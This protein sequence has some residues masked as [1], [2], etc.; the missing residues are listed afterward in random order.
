MLQVLIS[1]AIK[2]TH[3]GH[4]IVGVETSNDGNPYDSERNIKITVQ[5]T[6]IGMDS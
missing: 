3:E 6:G 4:V 2:F 5:D 1:N